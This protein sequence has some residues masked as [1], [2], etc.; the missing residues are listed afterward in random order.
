MQK[1][2]IHTATYETQLSQLDIDDYEM[3][4]LELIPD[5]SLTEMGKERVRWSEQVWIKRQMNDRVII[6]EAAAK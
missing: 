3:P 4:S 5:E 1:K 2:Q 6:F